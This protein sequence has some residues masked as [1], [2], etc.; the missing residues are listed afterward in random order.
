M[1]YNK[2]KTNKHF[3]LRFHM[4]IDE[5][6]DDVV[7]VSAY[8]LDD[9][10]RDDPTYQINDLEQLEIPLKHFNAN[11][12][13]AEQGQSYYLYIKEKGKKNNPVIEKI[14]YTK[15][16]KKEQAAMNIQVERWLEILKPSERSLDVVAHKLQRTLAPLMD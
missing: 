11:N 8:H 6:I 12:I 16:T 13:N 2:P 7:S 5:V 9:D 1:S 10:P 3:I 15:P 4:I 14:I